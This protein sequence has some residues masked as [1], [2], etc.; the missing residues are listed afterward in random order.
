META[1]RKKLLNPIIRKCIKQKLYSPF[2]DNIRGSYLED[3]QLISKF[4]K[5]LRF[6]L[7]FI[8]IY[9]EYAWAAS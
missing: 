2:K 9:S 6:L 5:K 4:K 7:C 3:T 8:D 1:I